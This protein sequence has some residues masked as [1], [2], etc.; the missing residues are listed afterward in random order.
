MAAA[1]L[2]DVGRH[3]DCR[4]GNTNLRW[5]LI[6]LAEVTGRHAGHADIVSTAGRSTSR[7]RLCSGW[8]P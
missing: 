1:S 8:R 6:H 4:W 7:R 3:P 2:N 5:M